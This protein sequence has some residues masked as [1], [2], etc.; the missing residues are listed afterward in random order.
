MDPCANFCGAEC[1]SIEQ[2]STAHVKRMPAFG[3]D[4]GSVVHKG[5]PISVFGKERQNEAPFQNQQI[6]DSTVSG[7]DKNSLDLEYPQK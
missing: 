2:L 5:G 4:M 1:H 7:N 3:Q 6:P